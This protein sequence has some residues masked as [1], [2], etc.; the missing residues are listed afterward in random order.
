MATIPWASPPLWR[1]APLIM[2]SWSVGNVLAPYLDVAYVPRCVLLFGS[3]DH[4][5]GSVPRR[6]PLTSLPFVFAVFL[7]LNY[8]CNLY[9]FLLIYVYNLQLC[10]LLRF[11]LFLFISADVIFF[12][13]LTPPS[14]SRRYN[15]VKDEGVGNRVLMASSIDGKCTLGATTT[16]SATTYFA[17][18]AF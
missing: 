4:A 13:R 5:H 2:C 8:I 17:L 14:A 9:M 1:A 16:C 11:R 10:E 18:F 7:L 3:S 6:L 12:L 15:G